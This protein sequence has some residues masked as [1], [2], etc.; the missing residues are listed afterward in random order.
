M[1]QN[2]R[3]RNWRFTE[4]KPEGEL[5]Y[6]FE[7]L[8][9]QGILEYAVYQLETY[10]EPEDSGENAKEKLNEHFQG[11]LVFKKQ[12]RFSAVHAILPRANLD[13]CWSPNDM[14]N[15]CMKSDNMKPGSYRLL[16]PFEHG[17]WHPP[18]EKCDPWTHIKEELMVKPFKEVALEHAGMYVRYTKG[19]LAL[20]S[21]LQK[22]RD[23]KT[24]VTLII[25]PTEKGKSRSIYAKEKSLYTKPHSEW[26]DNYFNQDAVLLDDFYGWIKYS[27]MLTIMDRYPLQVPFKGG[28]SQFN[29][30]R[31]YIT[32]NTYPHTWY[33][34]LVDTVEFKAFLRRIDKL[35]IWDSTFDKFEEVVS[36]VDH[37]LSKMNP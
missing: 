17:I 9:A 24:K 25:G 6:L 14:R 4:H 30:K 15:Y 33:R 13:V 35:I 31:L 19:M 34:N 10:D 32:S 22:E 20:N 12:L 3:A 7:E 21:L 37:L 29:S 16:G 2:K 5:E 28:Y 36:P 18:A 1:I 26:W 23:F 27:E 11:L 8:I